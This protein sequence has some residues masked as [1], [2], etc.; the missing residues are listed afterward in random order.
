MEQIDVIFENRIKLGNAKEYFKILLWFLNYIWSFTEWIYLCTT[1]IIK[2]SRIQGHV[3]IFIIALSPVMITSHLLCETKI[4]TYNLLS[5]IEIW[6]IISSFSFPPPSWSCFF[7]LIP[8]PFSLQAYIFVG[9]N[10][11]VSTI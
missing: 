11:S 6:E 10:F 8:L 5:Y 2:K 9:W 1:Y 7:F 4:L 3:K